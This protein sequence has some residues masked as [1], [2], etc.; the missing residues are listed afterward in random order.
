L[1]FGVSGAASPYVLDSALMDKIISA[2][3]EGIKD[4]LTASQ[5]K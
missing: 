2:V 5:P 3:A 4:Y 1:D